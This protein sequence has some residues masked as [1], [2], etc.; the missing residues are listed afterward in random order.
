MLIFDYCLVTHLH[1]DHFSPDYLPRD[2]LTMN[3]VVNRA[4]A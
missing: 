2:L 4:A 3:D 1:F